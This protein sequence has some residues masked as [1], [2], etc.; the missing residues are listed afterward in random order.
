L[1]IITIL[2]ISSL[3]LLRLFVLGPRQELHRQQELA[4]A[5]DKVRPKLEQAKV[6]TEADGCALMKLQVCQERKALVEAVQ[7]RIAELSHAKDV[8]TADSPRTGNLILQHEGYSFRIQPSFD[9]TSP[10]GEVERAICEDPRLAELDSYVA[11]EFRQLF[12]H[13]DEADRSR[14]RAERARWTKLLNECVGNTQCLRAE[15]QKSIALLL[16]WH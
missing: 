8:G 10:S 1:T 12:D 9:C 13:L 3:L 7:N 5:V 4:A 11:D 2:A 6:A 15:Y 14:L 16:S